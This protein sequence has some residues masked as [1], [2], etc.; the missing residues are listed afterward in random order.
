MQGYF[1]IKIQ[2]G[3]GN[4]GHTKR[5]SVFKQNKHILTFAEVNTII[6]TDRL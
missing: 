2:H 1:G 3:A 6:G 4:S 5:L